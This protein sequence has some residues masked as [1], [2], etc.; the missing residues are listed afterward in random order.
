MLDSVGHLLGGCSR[1][2]ITSECHKAAGRCIALELCICNST[3][4]NPVMIGDVGK[5]ENCRHQ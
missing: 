3:Y 2:A 4:G 5:A 1:M